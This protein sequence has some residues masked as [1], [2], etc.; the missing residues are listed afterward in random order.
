MK[1]QRQKRRQLDSLKVAFVCLPLFSL[2]YFSWF[3][4]TVHRIPTESSNT[5]KQPNRDEAKSL[6]A[7]GQHLGPIF[8]NI[9]VPPDSP[10]QHM[11]A[12]RIVEEQMLQRSWSDASMKSPVWYTQIGASDMLDNS[13]STNCR[14]LSHQST[15]DEVDTLQALWEY[16]Q[17]HPEQVVTYIHNKGSFHSTENNEKTRRTATKSALDCRNEM[18]KRRDLS[19]YN[20]CAGTM[21]ILPQYLCQANMWTAKCAYIQKLYQPNEYA[22]AMQRFYNITFS[23]NE[24]ACLR[25]YT[26]KEN[27]VGLGRY[28]YE[29]W[30]WSHPDVIPADVIPMRKIDFSEFPPVW[31]PSLSRSL[32]GSPKRMALDR[33]MGE[34]SFARL[35]GRLLEWNFLYHKQP[36]NDSWI[37]DYYKGYET[38][39]PAFKIK[40]CS[41]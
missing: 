7:N 3:Y 28:A 18:S 37:W 26:M 24:N 13:C 22:S 36:A 14:R 34:S 17:D 5:F 29:R 35:E 30:V 20:V 19:Q 10:E 40:H 31:K 38:G 21:I 8:Y 32:K 41:H 27:H 11:N 25:P 2:V 15:G 23:G 39:T 1:R 16:C 12:I 33:G 6:E 4:M 9:Y